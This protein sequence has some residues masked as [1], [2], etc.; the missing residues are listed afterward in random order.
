MPPSVGAAR[1]DGFAVP[2]G[3]FRAA[4]VLP[5]FVP[6]GTILVFVLRRLITG[7]DVFS[8]LAFAGIRFTAFRLY[9]S[10]LAFV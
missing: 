1:P 4:S 9:S 8:Y 2:L 6:S 10:C 3:L 5:V 7:V